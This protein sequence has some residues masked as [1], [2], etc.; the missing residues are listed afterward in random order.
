[1][2]GLRLAANVGAVLLAFLALIACVDF[3]LGRAAEPF[4]AALPAL[5]DLSLARILGWVF[6]PLAWLM[7]VPGN[8]V[9]AVGSLIGTKVAVN[10]FL[11]YIRLSA[12]QGELSHRSVVIATYVLCGFANFGSI[13]I[14]IGGIGG[15]APERRGDLARLG[16]KA[17][18]AG[19]LASAVTACLAGVLVT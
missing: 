19:L 15:I 17:M 5:E 7:G 11:A 9:E 13:A 1:L 14:Q 12:V 4:A 16:L 8:D 10:E 6:A 2:I 18:F 3:L